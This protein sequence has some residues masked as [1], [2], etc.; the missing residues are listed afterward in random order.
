MSVFAAN[1]KKFNSNHK[2]RRKHLHFLFTHNIP[3]VKIGKKY[4][5]QYISDVLQ[6]VV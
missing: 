6:L 4:K 5:S 3:S 2:R 1:L